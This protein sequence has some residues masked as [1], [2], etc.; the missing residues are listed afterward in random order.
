MA[1]IRLKHFSAKWWRNSQFR[2]LSNRHIY[3]EHN[4]YYGKHV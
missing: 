3:T 4:A 2:K 1:S